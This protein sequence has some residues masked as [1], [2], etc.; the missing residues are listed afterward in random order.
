MKKEVKKN[1]ISKILIV[2]LKIKRLIHNSNLF[3]KK[4]KTK[5]K[6]LIHKIIF[7]KKILIEKVNLIK[8]ALRIMNQKKEH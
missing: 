1:L 6:L 5:I 2:V 8:A 7:N 4:Y 3:I